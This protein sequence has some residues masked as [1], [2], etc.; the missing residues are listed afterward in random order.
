M[1]FFPLK[2]PYLQSNQLMFQTN[3]NY[4]SYRYQNQV[5]FS[6]ILKDKNF[7]EPEIAD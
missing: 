2:F 7:D 6:F 1:F 3:M 4:S 5:F